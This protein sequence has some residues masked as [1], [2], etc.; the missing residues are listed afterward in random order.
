MTRGY[1]SE[2]YLLKKKVINNRPL[3]ATI[4]KRPLIA[5][6]QSD[7]HDLARRNILKCN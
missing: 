4:N 3:I 2:S 6:T 1:R 7:K 5:T